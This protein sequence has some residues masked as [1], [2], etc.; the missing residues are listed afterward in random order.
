MNPERLESMAKGRRHKVLIPGLH[1]L[2]SLCVFSFFFFCKDFIII[3]FNI[4]FYYILI[5]KIFNV[6]K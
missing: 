1:K 5:I 2:L 4:S 3:N 6:V